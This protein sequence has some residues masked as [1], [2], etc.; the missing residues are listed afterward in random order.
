M[1]LETAVGHFIVGFVK[2]AII[3]TATGVVILG[4]V[5]L[6]RRLKKSRFGIFIL[7]ALLLSSCSTAPLPQGPATLRD[8]GAV[9]PAA[10]AS[11][12]ACVGKFPPEWCDK[13]V[14]H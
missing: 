13:E 7:A 9:N 11:Q 14:N 2:G 5:K 12:R 8:L 4:L 6:H 1:S 3:G 10:V